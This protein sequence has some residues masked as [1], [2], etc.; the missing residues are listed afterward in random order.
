MRISAFLLLLIL[1]HLTSCSFSWRKVELDNGKVKW[2][3]IH[4]T[5]QNADYDEIAFR[6]RYKQEF[7]QKYTGE[8]SSDTIGGIHY[9]Q[10][11][12]VRVFL[13]EKEYK[14]I[15][16]SGLLSAQMIYCK[17]D[18]LCNPIPNLDW[19]EAIFQQETPSFNGW[20]GHALIIEHFE[21]LKHLNPNPTIKRF[22]FHCD[23]FKIKLNGGYNVFL[24]ELTNINADKT[25]NFNAFI[26][27][28]QVTFLSLDRSTI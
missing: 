14:E 26:K 4:K 17:Y 3:N 18:S 21:E 25:T 12:S 24:L 9:V 27:D 5:S 8:I 15:L 22:K 23:P 11:D 13:F 28:S 2:K 10:F 19:I 20:T 1:S 6:S 16:V 7:Y